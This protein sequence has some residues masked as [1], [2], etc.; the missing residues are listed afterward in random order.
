MTQQMRQGIGLLCIAL[1]AFLFGLA[2]ADGTATW[3]SGAMRLIALFLGV[4]GLGLIAAGF[5]R[6]T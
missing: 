6:R 5:M 3:L 1:I 2:T 4:F